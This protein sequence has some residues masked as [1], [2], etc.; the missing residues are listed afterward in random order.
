MIVI[1]FLTSWKTG[2]QEPSPL[3]CS[4]FVYHVIQMVLYNSFGTSMYRKD[5]YLWC[6]FFFCRY[7]NANVWKIFTD[8]FDYF[9]LTALVSAG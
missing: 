1:D 4:N 7:G 8:L 9:P 3:R 2:F 5:K 6:F